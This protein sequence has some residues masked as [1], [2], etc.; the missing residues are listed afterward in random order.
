MKGTEAQARPLA[1]THVLVTRPAHQAQPLCSRVEAAGGVALRMPLLEI[2]PPQNP[3][4]ARRELAGAGACDWAIFTSANAVAQAL[5]LAPPR[6]GRPARMAAVGH[7]TAR[8]L[9]EACPDADILVPAGGYSSEHLLDEPAFRAISGARVLLVKGE[10]GR[11]QLEET[12]MARGAEVRVAEV[13]RRRPAAISAE[14]LD[15]ILARADVA[16]ITSA[17]ALEHLVALA[18]RSETSARLRDL[19]LVVPSARVLKM[20]LDWGFRHAPWVPARV[21]DA[22]IVATLVER[23]AGDES[24]GSRHMSKNP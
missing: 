13:Y 14:R 9:S 5:K 23:I 7:A 15:E 8:M 24:T 16:V 4:A 18:G 20:A 17:G 22:D 1:G 6:S 10:G 11:R 21:S 19:Q 12:L 2:H 3:E